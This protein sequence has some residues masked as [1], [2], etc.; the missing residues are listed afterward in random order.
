MCVCVWQF[1]IFYKVVRVDFI[2]K[3]TF[4]VRLEGDEGNL[5]CGYYILLRVCSFLT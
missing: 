2:G 5:E 3:V 1:S 4:E